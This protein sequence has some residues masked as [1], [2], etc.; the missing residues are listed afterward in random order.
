MKSKWDD[1]RKFVKKHVLAI[2]EVVDLLGERKLELR[3]AAVLYALE[4][5]CSWRSG[6]VRVTPRK[7]AERL[8]MQEK[9]VISSLTR[10]RKLELLAKGMDEHTGEWFY[11]LNPNLLTVGTKQ[12]MGLLRKSF[13]DALGCPIG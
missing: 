8:S 10:L 13:S 2:G 6:R 4:A 1:E 11:L 12:T 5:Y 7:L 9:H 3:D